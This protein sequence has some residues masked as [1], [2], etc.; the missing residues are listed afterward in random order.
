MQNTTDITSNPV[1][2]NWVWNWEKLLWRDKTGNKTA[3]SWE[4]RPQFVYQGNVR[5]LWKYMWPHFSM[6]RKLRKYLCR[7]NFKQLFYRTKT[8]TICCKWDG[9]KYV[10]IVQG[11]A[12]GTTSSF[13]TTD[14]NFT[15]YDKLSQT[16]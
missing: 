4:K 8:V 7:T 1:S 6:M 5:K 12:K 16:I 9:N 11:I 3:L 14:E 2:C 13:R 15:Q 10:C